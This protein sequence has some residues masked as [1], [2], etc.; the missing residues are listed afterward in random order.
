[1]NFVGSDKRTIA[2]LLDVHASHMDGDSYTRFD[3]TLTSQ[4]P[5]VPPP[6]NPVTTDG[7]QGKKPVKAAGLSTVPP[8]K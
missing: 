8:K 1:M 4:A 3:I 7:T 5:V 2:G 6:I